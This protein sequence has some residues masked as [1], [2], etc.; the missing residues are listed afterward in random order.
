M[1]MVTVFS[2]TYI[3]HTGTTDAKYVPRLTCNLQTT[4]AYFAAYFDH[5]TAIPS[6]AGTPNT[7]G[8]L[9]AKHQSSSLLFKIFAAISFDHYLVS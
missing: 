7:I 4:M 6:A 2:S 3:Y 5:I 9:S 1:K 8:K